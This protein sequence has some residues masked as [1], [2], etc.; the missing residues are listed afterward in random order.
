MRFIKLTLCGL[1]AAAVFT[2]P[3]FAQTTPPSWSL[4]AGYSNA[5][6]E[7][8]PDGSFAVRGNGFYNLSPVMGVGAELG[9][10]SLGSLEFT[11][12]I[13]STTMEVSTSAWQFTPEVRARGVSGSVRP[14]AMA[15]LGM[16]NLRASVD[17]VSA[18]ETEFGFNFGAGAQFGSGSTTFGIEGRWHSI[19][20][21]GDATDIVGFM[22]GINFN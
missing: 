22:G 15:G 20:T 4:Y 10:H 7:G 12:P 9:Y 1:V 5:T 11:D 21:E 14:Y 3:A 18:S 17:G 13:T 8:T 2:A 16:Y 19:M 6:G